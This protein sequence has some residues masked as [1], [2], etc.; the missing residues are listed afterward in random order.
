MATFLQT[1]VLW[2]SLAAPALV[3]SGNRVGAADV[4][5]GDTRSYSAGGGRSKRASESLLQRSS[6]RPGGTPPADDD[7]NVAIEVARVIATGD[8]AGLGA[9]SLSGGCS[10]GS[11]HQ[12]GPP[13]GDLGE[14]GSTAEGARL[15]G[16][17]D[18]EDSGG[19]YEEATAPASCQQKDATSTE[20]STPAEEL[21]WAL[22]GV[23]TDMLKDFF[24]AIIGAVS[25]VFC[26]M[27]LRLRRGEG[28]GGANANA[29]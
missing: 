11:A 18:E 10:D 2:L 21:P 12:C 4:D 28:R 7:E 9:A 22:P 16:S 1:T 3:A 24:M 8:F 5:P 27:S 20:G 29:R 23:F 26:R 19:G 14:N 13:L 25:F 15:P 17:G 6:V